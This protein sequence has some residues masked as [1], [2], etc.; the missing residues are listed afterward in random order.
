MFVDVFVLVFLELDGLE[1]CVWRWALQ[2][3]KLFLKSADHH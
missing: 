1:E 3:G 2:L